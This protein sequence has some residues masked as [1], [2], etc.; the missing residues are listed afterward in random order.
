MK[1]YRLSC[2]N[3]RLIFSYRHNKKTVETPIVRTKWSVIRVR[4]SHKKIPGIEIQVSDTWKLWT[5]S[6]SWT[7]LFARGSV[8][9][10]RKVI[11]H[12]SFTTTLDR[13][14]Q[15]LIRPPRSANEMFCVN[16]SSNQSTN[17]TERNI[18]ST[19]RNNSVAIKIFYKKLVSMLLN[20]GQ[21]SSFLIHNSIPTI[22]IP[23]IGFCAYTCGAFVARWLPSVQIQV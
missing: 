5:N 4:D 19:K 21:F 2:N 17:V 8:K 3:L 18:S 10:L 16:L 20:L 7:F 15:H 9:T 1:I 23:P 22:P 13:P 12:V 11:V 14:R 6:S